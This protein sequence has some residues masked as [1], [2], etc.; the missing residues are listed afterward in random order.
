LHSDEGKPCAGR[1]DLDGLRIARP[2]D[3]R[4]SSTGRARR[5]WAGHAVQGGSEL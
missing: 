3:I 2:I 5:G 1:R 4:V